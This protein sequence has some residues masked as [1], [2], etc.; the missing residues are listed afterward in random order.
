MF[1]RRLSILSA[2][3]F[4]VTGC[5]SQNDGLERRVSKLEANLAAT[6]ERSPAR[7]MRPQAAAPSPARPLS[8]WFLSGKTAHAYKLVRDSTVKHQGASSALLAST[9]PSGG[10]G[11]VMQTFSAIDYRGRRVRF[12]GAVRT[13]NVESWAGLW[14]RVDTPSP[15][16]TPFDNMRD[17]PISGTTAWKRYEVVLNVPNDAEAIHVGLLLAGS[18]QA[19]VD[20]G[21]FEVVCDDDATTPTTPRSAVNLDFD[22]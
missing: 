11:T 3:S 2:L 20:A 13:E 14:M 7:D 4:V 1:M 15:S 22:S 10:F 16:A 18:G 5:A 8:G 17:R 12:S 19:W 9:Q 21:R 6:P